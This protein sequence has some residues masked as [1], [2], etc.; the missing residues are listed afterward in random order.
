MTDGFAIVAQHVLVPPLIS[1]VV[2]GS[3]VAAPVAIE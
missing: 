3:C 1:S 2:S